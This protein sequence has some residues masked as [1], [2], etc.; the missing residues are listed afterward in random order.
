MQ[1]FPAHRLIELL[2]DAGATVRIFMPGT[3]VGNG[4][5]FSGTPNNPTKFFVRGAR[6]QRTIRVEERD[7]N[8]PGKG[9]V[10]VIHPPN[11]NAAPGDIRHVPDDGEAMV[12]GA[13]IQGHDT[14]VM[15]TM[16]GEGVGD[17]IGGVD[18]TI[19]QIQ[20]GTA[21]DA[22]VKVRIVQFPKQQLGYLKQLELSSSDL[23][24]PIHLIEKSFSTKNPPPQALREALTYYYKVIAGERGKLIVGAAWNENSPNVHLADAGSIGP[25]YTMPRKDLAGTDDGYRQNVIVVGA[26]AYDSS[27]NKLETKLTKAPDNGSN[28][29][30]RLSVLAPTTF[31]SID[32]VGTIIDAEG[33]SFAAPLVAGIAAEMML[34]DPTLKQPANVVKVAEMIEATADDIEAPG[35]DPRSAHGRVNFWKAILAAANGGLSQEGRTAGADGKD[36]F[37]KNLPLRDELATVWYGFEVRIK[38]QIANAQNA[39]LWFKDNQNPPQYSK[40]QDAGQKRPPIAGAAE[41]DVLAYFSTHSYGKKEVIT[42]GSVTQ[43]Q[44]KTIT[45]TGGLLPIENLYAGGTIELLRQDDSSLGVFDVEGNVMVGLTNP[46]DP[47]NVTLV[48]NPPAETAKFRNLTSVF[49]ILPSLPFSQTELANAGVPQQF[50]ARFS[51]KRDQ[52]VDKTSLLAVRVGGTPSVP[53]DVIFDLPISDRVDLRKAQGA[54]NATIRALVEAFD[55]FVF[56]VQKS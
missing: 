14:A 23:E 49:R 21:K 36:N 56:H 9:R 55:D 35:K 1:S 28:Y 13:V 39:V 26:S 24:S 46:L 53:A 38:A 11:D 12:G 10:A 27:A 29:G 44:G 16:M 50:L 54:N 19:S 8:P 5:D 22:Q 42:S 3:G 52:L 7:R 45:I 4:D 2:R 40:V 25:K 20:L 6:M 47:K 37:F 17:Q 43:I 15:A 48:Q 34:A 51:I 33:T 41:A 30:E 18:R 31:L 32:R